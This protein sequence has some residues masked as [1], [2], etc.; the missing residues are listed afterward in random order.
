[1]YYKYIL[2]P[3]FYII[4]SKIDSIDLIYPKFYVICC[5]L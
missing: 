3:K 4:Y 2:R 1:M 5:I